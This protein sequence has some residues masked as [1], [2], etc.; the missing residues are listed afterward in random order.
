MDKYE[1][2]EQYFGYNSFRGI[3]E[4]CIDSIMNQNDTIC[5]MATGGGKS[6]TFQVPGLM[7]EGVTI[8][9]SPLISLMNDQVNN[10]KKKKI[11][12]ITLN[13][14]ITQDEEADAIFR[15]ENND[16]KFIYISPERLQNP[17]YKML[18]SNIEIS[19]FVIDESH[20]LSQWGKDFRP[21]YLK[22]KEYISSLPKRPVVSCF[23]ATA[24]PQ[25][26]EDIKKGL[27]IKP[28][29]FKSSFDRKMLFYQ[30]IHTKDKKNYLKSFLK[31]HND[32]CGIVYTLTRKKAEEIFQELLDLGYKVSLYHGG[33][34]DDIKKKYQNEY[35]GNET[36][37]MVATS[38]FG[39][40]ID[41][42]DIRYIINYDLP[43][44]IDDLSQQQGR[45]SRDGGPGLCVLLYNES[46][47][48][49]N[50]YFINQLEWDEQL[51]KEEIK[52]LKK[53]KRKKL[54]DVIEYATTKRC[55]HEYLVSYYGELYMSYCNN[56]SNCIDQYE[57]IDVIDDAKTIL[58]FVRSINNRFG[59][60]VI[61]EAL[62]G[63]KSPTVKRNNLNYNRYFNKIKKDKDYVK[64][65]IVSLINDG[66]LKKD[67]KEYP[68]LEITSSFNDFFDLKEYKIKVFKDSNIFDLILNPKTIE[69][70]LLNFRDIKARRQGIPSYMVLK[71]DV[72]KQ[73]VKMKPKNKYELLNINGIGEKT[74]E[75][76]GNEILDIVNR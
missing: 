48:Y 61:A 2:L 26:I 58:L 4:E 66:Y 5:V 16:V 14:N 75:K 74:V 47:I 18:L 32:V 72:I 34:D 17:K 33:L 3:Q 22:I 68:T 10:L 8:V 36:N 29:V 76:Y 11:K 37:I 59:S 49:V 7:M 35:L 55:L 21:S 52:E 15:I 62:V 39:L 12:A 6:I 70:K 9:I 40:G 24:S 51:T 60:N 54:K 65:I 1:I 13:S 43:E 23:T 67:S 30:T 38:S 27:D 44:S 42:P 63:I 56:C 28:K 69:D 31:K 64:E 25:V 41:K 20:C 19:Q 57:Y 73:I 50:E 45:C 46:D 53:I 71:E